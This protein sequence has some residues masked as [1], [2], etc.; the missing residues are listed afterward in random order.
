MNVL[1]RRMFA[2]GGM[3]NAQPPMMQKPMAPPPMA[4]PTSVGTGITSGLVDPAQ[5]QMIAEQ[6]FAQLAGGV[7]NMLGDI[8][9]AE[10]TEEVIN[11]MRG[12]QMSLEERYEELAEFV[13]EGDAKKTPESV[14]ALVQPTFSMM[15]IV[16][17]QSPA[18]GIADAMPKAGGGL[19][20]GNIDAAS[21]VQ[22]PGM[23]EAMARIQ[24]GE[25]PVR[26]STGLNV[27]L[28]NPLVP[29]RNLIGNIPTNVQSVVPPASMNVPRTMPTGLPVISSP[30]PQL[31]STDFG[32]IDAYR[33][34]LRERL[35]PVISG[36][37]G[38]AGPS[39]ETRMK[40]AKDFLPKQRTTDEILKEYSDLLGTDAED[41][42]KTQAY[43]ALV[44]AGRDIAGSDKPLI[45]AALDAAADVAPSLSKI[46]SELGK[47]KRAL[48]LSARKEKLAQ[49]DAFR[50]TGLETL[51]QTIRDAASANARIESALLQME[52]DI[53]TKAIG[54]DDA[55][56][57]IANKALLTHFAAARQMDA[58]PATNYV[59]VIEK[60][61]KKVADIIAVERREG[62]RVYLGEDGTYKDLPPGYVV[63]N[64]DAFELANPGVKQ[65]DSKDVFIEHIQI[66]SNS[67]LSGYAER[68][69]VKRGNR[70]LYY[71]ENQKLIQAPDGFVIGKKNDVYQI[72][73]TQDGRTFITFKSGPYEGRRIM[74]RTDKDD[75]NIPLGYALEPPKYTID[76]TTN[77]RTLVSGNPMV[78]ETERYGVDI[79]Q[80]QPKDIR[81]LNRK[82][83]N[84]V[85]ALNDGQD[86][87]ESI[88][89]VVGPLSNLK[90]FVSNRISMFMPDS[91]RDWTEWSKTARG[92]QALKMFVK[93]VQASEALSERFA[94]REQEIIA[95]MLPPSGEFFSSPRMTLV[96]FQEM[97]RKMTNDVAFRRAELGE[98]L[99]PAVFDETT[100]Q[101][102]S[103]NKALKIQAIPTGSVNDPFVFGTPGHYDYL[104]MLAGKGYSVDEEHIYFTADQARARNIPVPAGEAGVTIQLKDL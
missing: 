40:M 100:K 90:S 81:L 22:A 29:T 79:T 68:P 57:K 26:A 65:D 66:P 67:T 73:S 97:M 92:E 38:G 11:A 45:G 93:K 28:T 13:G 86:I 23:G 70:I 94:Q 56:R 48:K 83:S 69:G 51:N 63:Y 80:L 16:Q 103:G 71:G 4:P 98:N 91:Q 84:T 37:T 36:M 60:D 42:A 19:L 14:L 20:A 99:S 54:L 58:L 44:Q 47:E 78:V 49:E 35:D 17:E 87:L 43:L 33:N 18:G 77:Q 61:G 3:A 82:I 75:P 21:P 27:D 95:E 46:A 41:A 101:L 85:A 104:G 52:T 9:S 15:D 10:S 12:D 72:D 89:E 102:V 32:R 88:P 59:K 8:D 76:P 31:E 2:N 24:A 25:A 7:Q 55:D 6:G 96:T 62:K 30:V 5:E 53:N 39:F 64:K 34:L 74:T 50:K 1:Q